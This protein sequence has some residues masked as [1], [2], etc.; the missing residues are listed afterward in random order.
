MTDPQPTLLL[1]RPEP[2]SRAFLEQCEALA[3]RPLAAVI[4][5][6][7]RIEATGVIPD[8]DRFATIIFTSGNGVRCLAERAGLRGRNVRTVGTRTAQLARSFGA[9]AVALGDD[10]DA[11]IRAAAKVES[12]A[13]L[14]RGTHVRGDLAKQLRNL[15]VE[16]E[17]AVIYHQFEQP[18]SADAKRL[19]AGKSPVLVPVFSPRSAGL[20][21]QQCPI[22]APVT[23]LAISANAADAWTGPGKVMIAE[24]PTADS[25]CALTI[26]LI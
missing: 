10:V 7:L 14:C 20:L 26:D 16:V 4:S 25:M 18:L 1:T 17:E 2:Q 3:G 11:F 5:P 22:T 21:A 23:V 24:A 8:L 12:P 9:K 13:L 15:G 19:L 6:I